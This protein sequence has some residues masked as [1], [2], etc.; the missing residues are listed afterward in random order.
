MRIMRFFKALV[1]LSG[2]AV[3]LGCLSSID[4]K[5]NPEA[6]VGNYFELPDMV[7]GSKNLEELWQHDLRAFS[8]KQQHSHC[9]LGIAFD[10]PGRYFPKDSRYLD[11]SSDNPI[12]FVKTNQKLLVKVLACEKVESNSPMFKVK[13]LNGNLKNTT[14]WIGA[15]SFGVSYSQDSAVEVSVPDDMYLVAH[16]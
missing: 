3:V 5:N 11:S 2:F 4:A 10:S 13:C 14:W 1:F 6:L 8:K 7:L 12:V 15:Q 9:A 16:K